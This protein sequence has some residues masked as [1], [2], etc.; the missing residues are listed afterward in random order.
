MSRGDR[1]EEIVR[2][3]ED[4]ELFNLANQNFSLDVS[5]SSENKVCVKVGILRDRGRATIRDRGR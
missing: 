3:D 5:K 2:T 4:R 1:R